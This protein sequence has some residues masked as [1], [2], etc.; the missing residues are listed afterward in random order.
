M[1][2][3]IPAFKAMAKCNEYLDHEAFDIDLGENVVQV[4]FCKECEYW[5]RKHPIDRYGYCKQAM[6]DCAAYH[7]CGW[8]V[9]KEKTE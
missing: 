1:K 4:V 9:S 8:G 3:H 6:Y 2:V 5:D 7:F